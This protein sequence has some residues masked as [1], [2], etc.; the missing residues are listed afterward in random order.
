MA[1][2]DSQR[3]LADTLAAYIAGQAGARAAKV[4]RHARLSGGAIQENHALSLELEGGDLPGRHDFVVRCDAPSAIATSLSRAQEFAVLRT[5]FEAGVAAPRPYWLCEDAAL[6]GAPF[7]VMAWAAGTASGRKLT[8]G[9]L[10]EEQGRALARRL[11]EELGRLHTVEPPCPALDFLPVPSM[12]AAHA[13]LHT[14]R[15]S[16]DAMDTADPVLE[17]ALRWL[18]RHAPPAGPIVLAHCD[19]RTG[20]YLVDGGRL[21]AILD[22]EFASWSDPHEDLGWLCARSWRFAAPGKE[23][24]GIGEKA[25]LFAGYEAVSGRRVDPA[26][27]RYWQVMASLRWAVIALQQAARH[28]SGAQRSLELALT[29]NMLPEIE[30][31]LLRHV[32]EAQACA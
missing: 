31:D 15:A 14:Y 27:V 13:R 4:L 22:W 23:V 11:G 2:A 10:S 3:N 32:E 5:A 21:S 19:F 7:Y 26:Q 12:P 6:I 25:D 9:A 24:G 18:A 1:A 16:L 8:G 28:Q 30:Q 17:Y 20:N 29:G